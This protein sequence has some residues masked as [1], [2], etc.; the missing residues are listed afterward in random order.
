MCMLT[1]YTYVNIR[2]SVLT[3]I[4]LCYQT[5]TKYKFMLTY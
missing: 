4:R 2:K 3:Y 1:Y 5:L